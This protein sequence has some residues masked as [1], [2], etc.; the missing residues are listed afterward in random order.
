MSITS[1]LAAGV[2]GLNANATKLASI[3]DNIANSATFGYKRAYTDFN[4][5]VILS[6]SPTTFAAGGVS[7]VTQRFVDERGQ[8]TGSDNP[9]DIAISGRGFLPTTPAA[10]LGVAGETDLLLKTTGSFRPNDEGVLV[11]STGFALLGWPAQIDGTIPNLPR[12]SAAGL[13]PVNIFHNQFS[14]NPTTE[15]GV[16]LNLPSASAADPADPGPIEEMTIEYFGNLGES[17]S[18][19]YRFE[20]STAAAN[21]WTLDIADTAT[22]G[23]VANYTLT[24]GTGAANGGTLQSV[25]TNVGNPYVAADGTVDV[26]VA[27]GTIEVDLGIYGDPNGITQLDTSFAPSNLTKNGSTVGSLRGVEI[28]EGGVVRAIYES[29]FT[30]PIFQVPVVDVPN[31][32]GL[33]AGEAQTF[34]VSR[35]SGGLFLWDAGEGPTGTTLGYARE[36]STTDVA[37]ELTE[38]IQTQ[39][40][41]STNA[42]VVQTV[43]EMLQETANLKR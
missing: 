25:V 31:A 29:G 9:T 22:G 6:G 36:A 35:D 16:S 3:S 1:S 7:T 39:R 26:D 5:L 41:Y 4:A 23:S 27:G 42:K 33:I 30:R 13:E 32:N 21:E 11:D 20:P 34:T 43:D 17:N 10:G 37:F 12:D 14:A 8:I 28:D 19:V 24:F 40:A 2:S 38:M 18:L 15:I